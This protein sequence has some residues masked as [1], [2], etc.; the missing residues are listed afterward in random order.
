MN[1]SADKLA[2]LLSLVLTVSAMYNDNSFQGTAVADYRFGGLINVPTF[3]QQ[4]YF[5]AAQAGCPIV[6]RPVCGVDGKTYQN[7]CFLKLAQ[8]P[9]AYD[10]WCLG[11][12]KEPAARPPQEVDPLVEVEATGFLRFGTPTSDVCPCN[13]VYYPVCSTKGVT[14][15]NLCRAKCNG[16]IAAQV[17]PCYDFYYK[18]Q[19]NIICKCP[20][21]QEMICGQD[22]VTYENTCVLKCAGANFSALNFC[23]TPCACPFI[24]KPVCG[25]DGR[26][27][28][29]ECELACAKTQKAFDGRCD[30]NP[31]QKC[32]YCLGDA[33]PVCGKDGRTY[34]NLCYLKCN[35]KELATDGPCRPPSP[36]GVCVCPR[37]YLPVCTK[38]GLT[39]D[40]ECEARCKQQKIVHNGACVKRE[41]QEQI[42]AQQFSNECLEKCRQFGAKPVCG[43]D[44]RTYGN[45]CATSCNSVLLVKADTKRPCKPVI[46]EHCP[47]NTNLQPVCGVDGKTYLNICTLQCAGINKAWDGPCAVIGNYGYI[48]SNYYTK[49]TGAGPIKKDKKLKKRDNSDETSDDKREW[50]EVSWKQG[51]K[52][53]EKKTDKNESKS[54]TWNVVVGQSAAR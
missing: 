46:H 6:D 48:M 2:A 26:N 1:F 51:Q 12:N 28:V 25:I 30:T 39:F 23:P 53:E 20:F 16:A 27:Y 21:A 5:L 42:Y 22:G 54:T 24:Y 43:S 10:G 32:V 37:I 50:K 19:A 29:N 14:Y 44:G 34:D 31:L 17:G 49:G 18:P 11:N 38:E 3:V 45:K 35:G 13:D 47:C 33:S 36:D 7:D 8:V 15:S 52:T 41:E 9:K 40:N 4:P